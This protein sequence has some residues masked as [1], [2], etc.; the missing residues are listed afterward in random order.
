VGR[1]LLNPEI[2]QTQLVKSFITNIETDETV[3]S[4]KKGSQLTVSMKYTF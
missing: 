3:L 1:N 2:K 4:Y